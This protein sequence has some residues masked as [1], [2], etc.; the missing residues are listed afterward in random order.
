MSWI[1][2]TRQTGSQQIANTQ[3]MYTTCIIIVGTMLRTMGHAKD[4][5]STANTNNPGSIHCQLWDYT[6]YQNTGIMH[7]WM[8]AIVGSCFHRVAFMAFYGS[9]YLAV[10]LL[11]F[12]KL[13]S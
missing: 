10:L 11:R 9:L 13:L 1:S 5:A 12:C 3:Y 4:I 8:E 7:Q 6:Y 2:R